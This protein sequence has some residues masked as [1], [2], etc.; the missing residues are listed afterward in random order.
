MRRFAEVGATLPEHAVRMEEL[1]IRVNWVIR[2]M[3]ARGVFV[4]V[5]DERYYIDLTAAERFRALRRRR[6]LTFVELC[7]LILILFLLLGDAVRLAC[8]LRANG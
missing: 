7:L 6:I 2:R 8:R 5:G 3:I 1:G 4:P